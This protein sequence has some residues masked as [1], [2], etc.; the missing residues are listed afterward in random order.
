MT[1]TQVETESRIL[2]VTPHEMSHSTNWTQNKHR[3]PTSVTVWSIIHFSDGISLRFVVLL[4]VVLL[5]G[6]GWI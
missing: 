3:T 2:Q 1:L 4:V 6:L 5:L